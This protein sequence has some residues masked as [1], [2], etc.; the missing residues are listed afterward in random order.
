MIILRLRCFEFGFAVFTAVL[1]SKKTV[2][3][4]TH[5][6]PP[7]THDHNFHTNTPHFVSLTSHTCP[8]S[9]FCTT[10]KTNTSL[11]IPKRTISPASLIYPIFLSHII[12]PASHI[13]S[14]TQFIQISPNPSTPPTSHT[15]RPSSTF[16]YRCTSSYFSLPLPII[17]TNLTST[18]LEP[19][20]LCSISPIMIPLQIHLRSY[21]I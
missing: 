14:N 4:L 5:T 10:S 19:I 21:N 11:T 16:S 18:I 12:T 6:I 15:I 7:T 2:T 20:Q 8:T 1:L 13:T 3:P 17:P 9:S